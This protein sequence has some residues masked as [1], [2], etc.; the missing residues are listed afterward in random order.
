MSRNIFPTLHTKPSNLPDLIKHY[1]EGQTGLLTLLQNVHVVVR[2]LHPVNSNS[3]A[4]VSFLRFSSVVIHTIGSVVDPL[5]GK[6]ILTVPQSHNKVILPRQA[7]MRFLLHPIRSPAY[8]GKAVKKTKVSSNAVS[9]STSSVAPRLSS[10]PMADG[11]HH[12]HPENDV[13]AAASTSRITKQWGQ[14]CGPCACVLRFETEVDDNQRIRS[15]KYIAKEVMTTRGADGQF[16]PVYTTRT[17]K[18]MLRECQ[19]KSLH[20]LAETVTSF[21]PEKRIENVRPDFQFTR[22]SSAFRH[23]VLS[24]HDLPTSNTHC[25]DVVE[26]AFTAMIDGVVPSRRRF[27]VD[28]TKLLR[29]EMTQRPLV[30]MMMA[31]STTTSKTTRP[32]PSSPPSSSSLFPQ[33]QRGRI[34]YGNAGGRLG[35]DRNHTSMTV[36]PRTVS[37]L[38][39]FDLNA[40]YWEDE[41]Y[42]AR[43]KSSSSSSK[44]TKFSNTNDWLSFVDEQYENGHGHGGEESSA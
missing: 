32:T 41:E 36:P 14:Q 33:Y 28:Y 4:W 44:R 40:E 1:V 31:S 22:S 12:G 43:E 15:A 7:T 24:S 9:P 6:E 26:E 21:L 11:R 10:T 16:Q 3:V 17:N 39:M 5:E 2:G 34:I 37:T 27:N 25:F 29:A 13:G 35:S 30:S 19:C 38:N 20:A 42:A 23:A 18:P 8:R